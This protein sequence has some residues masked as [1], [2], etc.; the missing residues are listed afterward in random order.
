MAR[1]LGA[2]GFGF[3]RGASLFCGEGGF[4]AWLGGLEP[5]ASVLGGEPFIFW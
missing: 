3:W 2:F 4:W 5:L 1:W